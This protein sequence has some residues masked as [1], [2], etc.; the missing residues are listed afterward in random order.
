VAEA[1][2]GGQPSLYQ[3]FDSR[4]AVYDALFERGMQTHA[5][6]IAAAVDASA[7]GW[8][9]VRAAWRET[10]RFASEQ[11]ALAQLL[12]NRAVP[13]FVPSAPAYAPS[14]RSAVLMHAAMT[15][16]VDRGELHPSAATDM[17]AAY[18]S[19]ARPPGWTPWLAGQP[20]DGPAEDGGAGCR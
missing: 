19:P 13:G 6:V 20:E 3:Y 8:A 12:F 5:A 9:A 1:V 7:P 11:P 14:L 4:T 18:F 17:Y 2:H 15:A 16:A 10:L